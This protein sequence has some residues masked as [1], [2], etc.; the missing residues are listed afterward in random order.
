[1][2]LCFGTIF[3]TKIVEVMLNN[4]HR[5]VAA[6]DAASP[7]CLRPFSRRALRQGFFMEPR[8]T[9]R[10]CGHSHLQYRV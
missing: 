8:L 5:H 2:I 3:L 10:G 1:M 9:I 7:G 6:L 4:D